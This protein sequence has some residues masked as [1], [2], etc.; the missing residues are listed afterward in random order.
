MLYFRVF[1]SPFL[2]ECRR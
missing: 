1:N 2:L